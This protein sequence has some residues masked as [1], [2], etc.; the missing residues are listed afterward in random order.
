MSSPPRSLKV[1]L[2]ESIDYA[3]LFPPAK[4]GMEE[5]VRNFAS[6][7][8]GP[9]RWALGRF[10]VPLSR[11]AEFDDAARP[12]LAAAGD[13][14][15]WRVSV[16]TGPDIGRAGEEISAFESRL[17]GP[18]VRPLVD[19]AELRATAPADV[20]RAA[21]H[22]A[23][24]VRLFFEIPIEE[25]PAPLIRAIGA[26]GAAAK[27]RTGG[28][29]ADM[30]P[31]AANLLRFLAACVA[32]GVRFK[33]TAGLHH[34]VRAEYPLTYDPGSPSGTMYGFLNVLLAA[35]ALKAG[36]GEGTARA[37][38]EETDVAAF[39]FGDEG[40]RWR[41]RSFTVDQLDAARTTGFLSF[42]S[43]SFREPFGDLHTLG[44]I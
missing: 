2:A 35:A 38:L 42:G 9:D 3:G 6:Y 29:K 5:A 27:V 18:L 14:L 8:A 44:M 33:A 26:A 22:F 15:P 12:H 40:A 10:V 37:I 13:A 1:L 11:L 24:R 4:L 16:L 41:E 31:D 7:A 43:C 25:E 32:G 36:S 20:P 19:T 39:A 34:P 23:A 17:S 28:I 30:I 21:G